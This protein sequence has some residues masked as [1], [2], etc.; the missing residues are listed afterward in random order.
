MITQ[1]QAIEE[2]K[3]C[4]ASPAYFIMNHIKVVHP[5]LGLTPFKL[6]PFQKRIL[7]EFRN[8]RFN[9]LRKF[10]Q[11][12]CTTLTSAY[13]LW[14]V[15]FHWHK[16]VAI[17]SIGD[18]ESTEVLDKIKIMYDELPEFLKPGIIERNKHTLKLKTKSII[19]SRPSGKTSGRSIAGSLL[20]IDEGAFIERI[21][22][23]WAS[24][25]PILS[26]G[27]KAIVLSTVNGVGNWYHNLYMGAV[28]GLNKFHAIDIKWKEH[29]EYF[30]NPDYE[31]LYE[32]KREK[33]LPPVEEWE[34]TTKSNMP[35]KKW[36][37]EFEC[38]GPDS[39]VTV[40]D[41]DT[42]EIKSIKIADLYTLLE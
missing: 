30:P 35:Y 24:A 16:T 1:E 28:E 17:L 23:I 31:W 18:A 26:T 12:G 21:D 19:K 38:I 25:Y 7:S 5:V 29:P 2:F 20:I 27:G 15:I 6:Y 10:R 37:Q 22:E 42:G 13:A 3:K 41:K 8:N 36:L 32:L 34:D 39:I 14:M 9:I 4:K 11:A 40:K 33:G